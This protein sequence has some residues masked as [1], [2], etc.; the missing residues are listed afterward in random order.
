MP[1]RGQKRELPTDLREVVAE[2]VQGL[3]GE[4]TDGEI[5][6]TAGVGRMSVTRMRE[7]THASNLDTLQAV[8]GALH[9]LPH[10][11]LVRGYAAQLKKVAH[12]RP[13]DKKT[14]RPT[15]IL[16]VGNGEPEKLRTKGKK[17]GRE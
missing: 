8:A 15:L 1:K 3:V 4:R 7:G 11:L 2:N 13:A 5:A 10:M 17:T 9:T 6:R 16:G 14:R 12:P